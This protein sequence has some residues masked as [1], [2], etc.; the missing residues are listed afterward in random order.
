[1]W[2]VTRSPR[3][4]GQVDEASDEKGNGTA[5][6]FSMTD[7]STTWQ[8][9]TLDDGQPVDLADYQGKPLLVLFFNIG[10]HGC[11]ARGLPVAAQIVKQYPGAQLVAIH[12][13][14]GALGSD[15]A[16]VRAALADYDINFPVLLDD[17]HATYDAYGAEGTPHWLFID[18]DGRVQKS[19]FGSQPNALQRI[20]YTLIEQFGD[21]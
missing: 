4:V 5:P 15:P 18:A 21:N 13:H 16:D 6:E 3:P 14:W 19:I 1:M 2:A 8:V 20:E 12:S 11:M 10:C 17:G 9:R 7:N